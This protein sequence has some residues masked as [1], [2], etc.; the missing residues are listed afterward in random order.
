MSPFAKKRVNKK[1]PQVMI[2][3]TS[4]RILSTL[5]TL[6]SSPA[7]SGGNVSDA[8]RRVAT[9]PCAEET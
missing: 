9:S 4:F 6:P 7:M 8:F 1:A 5:L 3:M 2:D